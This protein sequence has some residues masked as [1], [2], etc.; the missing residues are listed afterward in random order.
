MSLDKKPTRTSKPGQ[1]TLKNPRREFLALSVCVAFTM[2]SVFAF[3]LGV[4][5]SES[6]FFGPIGTLGFNYATLSEAK[7][8]L[9]QVCTEI[10]SIGDSTGVP[11]NPRII[12]AS[13]GKSFVNLNI[14]GFTGFSG[15]VS[16]VKSIKR[17]GCD[18]QKI[19]VYL[20][21]R[22]LL[23]D[24]GQIDGTFENFFSILHLEGTLEG[25]FYLVRHIKI[26]PLIFR[27]S[28]KTFVRYV[29]AG[30]SENGRDSHVQVFAQKLFATISFNMTGKDYKQRVEKSIEKLVR[31]KGFIAFQNNGRNIKHLC[32]SADQNLNPEDSG[33]N[34]RALREDLYRVFP[35]ERY[36][37]TMLALPKCMADF[38]SVL[39]KTERFYDIAPVGINPKYFADGDHVNHEGSIII[40]KMLSKELLTR[41]NRPAKT[42]SSK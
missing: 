38:Q 26:L 40:S 32:Q 22:V 4:E 9:T 6:R 18:P 8:T 23:H 33:G 1:A 3:V 2:V 10:V 11:L 20:T 24:F 17:H 5:K 34:L 39:K 7:A 29:L 12:E 28:A 31:T 41:L 27:S 13:T 37:F 15:Y 25:L 16:Q 42:K 35:R 14:Y 30:V 36:L 21:P 19:I